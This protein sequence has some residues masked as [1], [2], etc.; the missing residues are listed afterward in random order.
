MDRSKFI[1]LSEASYPI[2]TKT[3]TQLPTVIEFDISSRI[4]ATDISS[5][6]IATHIIFTIIH[7]HISSRR[8]KPTSSRTLALSNGLLLMNCHF[9]L[10]SH[11]QIS[12][13]TTHLFLRAGLSPPPC[14][15]YPLISAHEAQRLP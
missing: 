2:E 4:I 9:I 5:R 7:T 6:I 1:F 12:V 8:L 10:P 14:L 3:N 11:F 15:W 13:L